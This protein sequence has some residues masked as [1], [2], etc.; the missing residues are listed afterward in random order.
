MPLEHLE[1]VDARAEA[2][3]VDLAEPMETSA[4]N[5]FLRTGRVALSILGMHQQ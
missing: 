3:G 4:E 5:S 1:E 2:L